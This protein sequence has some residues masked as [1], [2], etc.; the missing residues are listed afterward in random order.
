MVTPEPKLASELY[1]GAE[2]QGY[3]VF[4]VALNDTAPK[5]AFSRK[6]DG[7]GATWFKAY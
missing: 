1:K 3:V 4:K 2:S 7:S 5:I 6:Y